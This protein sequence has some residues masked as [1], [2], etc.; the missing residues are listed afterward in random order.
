MH[1]FI[2][3]PR[4][5]ADRIRESFIFVKNITSREKERRGREEGRERKEEGGEGKR[6]APSVPVSSDPIFQI[7][8]C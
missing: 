7:F 3:D 6:L 5:Q 4:R 2:H 8:S 1:T